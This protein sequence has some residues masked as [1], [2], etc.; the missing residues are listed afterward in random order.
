MSQANAFKSNLDQQLSKWLGAIPVLIPIFQR[1]NVVE[2][3]N[4]YCKSEAD[5]D[6][7]TV[8]LI[9]ALNR[10]MAP[11]PLYKVAEWMAK[12]VLEETLL[13]PAEKLADLRIGDLLDAIHR[14]IDP[15]W[16]ELIHRAISE[17]GINIDFIHYD[18]TSIYFERAYEGAD[19]IEYGYSR[20]KRPDCKR[21]NLRLNVTSEDAIPLAFKVIS[22]STADKTTP[23]EN[24]HALSQLINKP[25]SDTTT[26]TTTDGEADDNLIIVSDQAM[27]SALVIVTYH[28]QGVGYLGPLPSLKV[29]DPVLMSAKT[30][31]LLTNPLSYCPKNQKPD[32][33]R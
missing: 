5:I 30:E 26:T 6:S 24:M 1:L 23:I 19:K 29:Y 33:N 13:I 15:I 3:I 11:K 14:Y 16:N 9:L 27:L 25:T 10:L 12:T 18:I 28:K 21:V 7:G 22:G 31:E 17:F 2:V 4:R 8:A 20:D 32:I